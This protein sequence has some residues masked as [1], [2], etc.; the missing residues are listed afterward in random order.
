MCIVCGDSVVHWQGSPT[1]LKTSD[2]PQA[3]RLPLVITLPYLVSRW[4]Q[5]SLTEF[6]FLIT[7]IIV[8]QYPKGLM[9]YT[10]FQCA[11]RSRGESSGTCCYHNPALREL[12]SGQVTSIMTMVTPVCG[13]D[14][15]AGVKFC[16][17]FVSL[18]Y[19]QTL[20]FRDI[21][22]TPII[23]AWNLLTA[24]P[25]AIHKLRNVALKIDRDS[26]PNHTIEPFTG[27]FHY[28]CADPHAGSMFRQCFHRQVLLYR[29]EAS[30][31]AA[32]AAQGIA[33]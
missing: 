26:T 28:T 3:T 19:L 8:V 18:T 31:R 7:T 17:W 9:A 24:I 32:R 33:I 21:F 10:L 2:L 27:T 16:S 5:T 25:A 6:H 4:V 14:A 13:V 11:E 30:R 20:R 23:I 12:V 22:T 1:N 15:S 29:S